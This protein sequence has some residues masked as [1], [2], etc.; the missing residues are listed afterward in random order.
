MS[1]ELLEVTGLSKAFGPF[2]AVNEVSFTLAE[3]ESLG[4][5]GE[6]GSG[7]TTLAR[8]LLGLERP[9]S[10]TIRCRGVDRT[11][12]ARAS[13]VRRAR[14]QDLQIVF[15]DPY[16]SLDPRYTVRESLSETVRIYE[17]RGRATPARLTELADMVSL[18]PRHLDALPANLSGGQ[19]QRVAIARALAA[20]PRCVVLD[21]AVAALDVSIQAQILNLLA[22]IREE[23]GVSL[24]FITHDLG[25]VRQVTDH[26]VV[27]Q[28][29]AI[30][31]SGSTAELLSNPQHSYTQELIASVPRPGWIP[32]RRTTTVHSG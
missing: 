14:G 4:I 16:L 8:M 9:T 13:R 12:P 2:V 15:Q 27:M 17:G 25:V 10:G 30:V 6:S 19:R 3:G 5:I 21:E 22:D 32:R 24:L 26:A 1:A 29:G 11:V 7:K 23:L 31:E 18:S 20:G 28:R